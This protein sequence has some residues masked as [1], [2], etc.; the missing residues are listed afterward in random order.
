MF[1]FGVLQKDFPWKLWTRVVIIVLVVAVLTGLLLYLSSEVFLGNSYIQGL[2]RLALARGEI[3]RKAFLVY[4]VT[5]VMVIIGLGSV[6]LFYSHR[7]AGPLFRLGKEARR[8]ARGDLT[9]KVRL[10][11]KDAVHP[12]AETMNETTEA[13]R[14]RVI[15]LRKKVNELKSAA[16]S[17]MEVQAEGPEL[18]EKIDQLAMY[19][20]Q[21]QET[22]K[23]LRL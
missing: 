23:E 20:R 18:D 4:I 15:E 6:T 3:V 2:Q 10:R 14:Q 13:Y 11:Q 17:V 19:V 7:I 1:H 12:L 5:G 9:V 21:L 22:L 8:I 16:T